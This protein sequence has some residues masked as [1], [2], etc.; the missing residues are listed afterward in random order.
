MDVDLATRGPSGQARAAKRL[1]EKEKAKA[2]EQDWDG[3]E[4][5]G[6][7]IFEVEAVL[8]VVGRGAREV[9]CSMS[10]CVLSARFVPGGSFSLAIT[11]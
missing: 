8:R 7:Q 2:K 5:L 4:N 9:P 11:V 1:L 3:P 6:L 10:N